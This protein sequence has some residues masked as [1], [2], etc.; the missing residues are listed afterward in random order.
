MRLKPE[1]SQVA[2]AIE[3]TRL[4]EQV[5]CVGYDFKPPFGRDW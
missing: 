4:F 5:S 1:A 2:Y 3:R